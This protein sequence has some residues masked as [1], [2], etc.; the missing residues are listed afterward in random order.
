LYP[1]S[2]KHY[3]GRKLRKGA[4]VSHHCLQITLSWATHITISWFLWSGVWAVLLCPLCR[5]SQGCSRA[6][7]VRPTVSSGSSTGQD[8]NS[9]SFSLLAEV[10]SLHCVMEG[11]GFLLLLAR[12][13]A[14]HSPLPHGFLQY[15]GLTSGQQGQS[16]WLRWN[17]I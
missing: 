2:P 17:F 11:P 4:S 3:S 6:V 1:R 16:S 7:S 5:F 9:G 14:S 8:S 12:S 13:W 10:I 15:G